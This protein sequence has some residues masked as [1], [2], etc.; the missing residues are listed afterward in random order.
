[1]VQT[2]LS[3]IYESGDTLKPYSFVSQGQNYPETESGSGR[4]QK[5]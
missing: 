5:N 4:N 3:F 1:M 2:I